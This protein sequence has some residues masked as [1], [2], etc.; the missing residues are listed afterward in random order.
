MVS[1]VFWTKIITGEKENQEN[2]IYDSGVGE[3]YRYISDLDDS[4][5]ML[6]MPRGMCTAVLPTKQKT[7]RFLALIIG[8]RNKDK[9]KEFKC[10]S[11]K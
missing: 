10:S 4:G 5:E 3:I 6:V 1:T 2:G 11:G 7:P 9:I 8:C